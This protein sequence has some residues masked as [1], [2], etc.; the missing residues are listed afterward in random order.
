MPT[1][2]NGAC[3]RIFLAADEAGTAHAAVYL[4][5]D[6]DTVYYLMSGSDPELRKSG[7]VSLCLW[8]AI[9]YSVGRFQR[10]DFEG[11]VVE[12]IERYFRSFGSE[13]VEYYRVFRIDSM[14]IRLARL[15]R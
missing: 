12:P 13:R 5:W 10:F 8:E 7:A 4:V 9:R 11:S 3:R 15:I 1:A 14:L 2:N 6:D